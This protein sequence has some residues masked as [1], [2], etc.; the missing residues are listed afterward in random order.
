MRHPRFNGWRSTLA[1]GAIAVFATVAWSQ[2][3]TTTSL[4]VWQRWE[5]ALTSARRY[6]NPY[7]DVTLRV[8]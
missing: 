8:H 6:D 1:L 5:H 4:H 7:A 2:T 3:E